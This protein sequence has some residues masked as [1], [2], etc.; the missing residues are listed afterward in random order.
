MNKRSKKRFGVNE[1]FYLHGYLL[2]K[3]CGIRTPMQEFI[4]VWE[5]S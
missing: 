5:S 2:R 4:D 1:G 3:A